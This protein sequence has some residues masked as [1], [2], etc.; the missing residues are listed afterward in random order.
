MTTPP[1]SKPEPDPLDPSGPRTAETPVTPSLDDAVTLE[2]EDDPLA[3]TER[4]RGYFQ[5]R[6]DPTGVMGVG[7]TVSVETIQKGELDGSETTDPDI[8]T[9]EGVPWVPPNDQGVSTGTG[10]SAL[11]EPF[12]GDHRP[13]PQPADDAMTVRVREAL[14]ADALA[15]AYADSLTIDAD[16]DLVTLTGRVATIEDLEAVLAVA[17]GVQGIDEVADELEIE[18]V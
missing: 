11:D 16:G 3:V 8:A 4:E 13:S 6:V 18:A 2:D 7:D 17:A 15:A 10:F 12:D 1:R 5:A 9:E 14:R